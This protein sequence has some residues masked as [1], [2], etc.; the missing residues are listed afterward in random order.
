MSVGDVEASVLLNEYGEPSNPVVAVT[1]SGEGCRTYHVFG[2]L[3]EVEAKRREI[4]SRHPAVEWREVPPSSVA[5]AEVFFEL[6][7]N[8]GAHV[9][10]RLAAKVAFEWL[11]Q[12]R[13]GA[14][15]ADDEFRGIRE[16]IL[17]GHQTRT[18]AAP[19][20][21]ERLMRGVLDF[22]IPLHAVAVFAHPEDRNLGAF[23]AFYGLFYF[24]VVLSENHHALAGW[25]ELQ[26]EHPQTREVER[27][28]FRTGTGA[29][30]IRWDALAGGF[31]SD[32]SGVVSTAS[33]HALRKLEQALT[34]FYGD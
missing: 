26:T 21:E 18:Y 15:V 19:L 11:A 9:F 32:P 29:V 4:S 33:R 1:A 22:S 8:L 12:L 20:A 6:D 17:Q 28:L 31:A 14:V 5:S 23:V 16:Y 10:R 7:L 30:R 13:L 34:R 27:P 25:D 2:T 24:W 3:E